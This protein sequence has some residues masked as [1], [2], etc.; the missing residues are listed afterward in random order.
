MAGRLARKGISEMTLKLRREIVKRF[1]A[2]ESLEGLW[3][4]LQCGCLFEFEDVI[5]SY[6][7]GEFRLK[8]KRRK[9]K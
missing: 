5:R 9:R 7:K 8:P 1:S 4:E 6:M 3:A 2:G